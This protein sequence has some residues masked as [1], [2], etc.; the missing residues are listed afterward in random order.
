V[1]IF[2]LFQVFLYA[3]EKKMFFFKKF[4]LQIFSIW[5]HGSTSWDFWSYFSSIVPFSSLSLKHASEYFPNVLKSLIIPLQDHFNVDLRVTCIKISE[6]FYSPIPYLQWCARAPFK[7]YYNWTDIIFDI[8]DFMQ[9]A[10]SFSNLP[11]D[12]LA[13][14]NSF[15]N[16]LVAVVSM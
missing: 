4:L 7:D 1:Q 8:I 9:K 5:T 2:M 3:N 6:L 13:L 11:Y 10:L 16:S 12:C 14:W 15:F